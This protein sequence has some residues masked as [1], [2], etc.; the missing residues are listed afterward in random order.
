MFVTSIRI[1]STVNEPTAS[2]EL[3]LL[4]P[5]IEVLVALKLYPP[6]FNLFD[7]LNVPFFALIS[8]SALVPAP[9]LITML[10]PVTTTF[11]VKL[12]I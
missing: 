7:V 2:K 12:T 11:A 5:V 10:L 4:L 8:N 3:K 6:T 1:G 9:S